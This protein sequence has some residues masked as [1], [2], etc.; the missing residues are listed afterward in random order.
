MKDL[1]HSL[2][3][4]RFRL[5]NNIYTIGGCLLAYPVPHHPL[6]GCRI[7]PVGALLSSINKFG[8]DEADTLMR[9]RF[10]TFSLFAETL[11]LYLSYATHF[12]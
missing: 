1:P 10:I 11:C 8:R 4:S 2:R 3:S 7:R 9:Q 5:L 12:I 6:V